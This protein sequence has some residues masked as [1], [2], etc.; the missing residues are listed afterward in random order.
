MFYVLKYL[1]CHIQF[2]V[3]FVW[4]LPHLCVKEHCFLP[5]CT[6]TLHIR[7]LVETSVVESTEA[8]IVWSTEPIETSIETTIET[9][10]GTPVE[11]SIVSIV[12]SPTVA[13]VEASEEFSM[14]HPPS[15]LL[16]LCVLH[17]LLH[18]WKKDM[19]QGKR[20]WIFVMVD[21]NARSPTSRI[22]VRIFRLGASDPSTKQLLLP[23]G[24]SGQNRT[25]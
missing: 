5:I 21:L 4:R 6:L 12:H 25:K 18:L 9:S 17:D 8:S 20:T 10:I 22:V 19:L 23:G 1:F 3:I 7:S 13:I 14:A 24:Q 2:T 15:D 11:T 16:L